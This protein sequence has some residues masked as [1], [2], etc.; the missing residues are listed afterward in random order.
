MFKHLPFP[1]RLLF[2]AVLLNYLAQ[3]PYNL[4]LYGLNLNPRGVLLLGFTFVWFVTGF[5]LLLQRQAIG[6]WLTLGFVAV[7]VLFYFYN[8]IILMFYGYGLLYHLTHIGDPVVWVVQM[9]GNVNAVAAAYG[10]VYLVRN[11]SALIQDNQS[12]SLTHL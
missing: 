6:Y 9:I 2:A 5:W 8:Q 12:E 4:H 11:R 10:L 1:L 3:I 7:Q